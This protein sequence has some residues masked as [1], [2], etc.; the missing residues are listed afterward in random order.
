MSPTLSFGALQSVELRTC[1]ADEAR[2]LTP[3]VA[4]EDGLKLLGAALDIELACESCEVPVGPFSADILA[5]DLTTNSLVVIENQ[6]ERTNHDHFGKTLTYA[7]VLG[8]TTVV[9]IAR[10]FT[11]E[12]RK[13]LEWLNELARGDLQ[14]YGV[15]LQVWKIGDSAPAPRFEV[16]CSPNELVQAAT[17]ARDSESSPT[18]QL[19]LEFWTAVKEALQRTGEFSSLHTPRGQYWFDIAIGRSSMNL[20]L[21]ANTDDKRV[22]IRLY[23]SWRVADAVLRQLE[24]QRPEIDAAIGESLEWNPHPEKSDKTIRLV[25]AADIGDRSAWPEIISWLTKRAI[26]FKQVF[27]PRLLA[28]DLSSP[29][30]GESA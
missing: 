13:A 21:T 8:A 14:L 22:G 28:I 9:W 6:L 4:S 29:S 17:R 18:R 5:R 27:G 10:T 15:E 19:Q 12:H 25:R 3:W 1:W 26:V 16:V 2:N 24:P 20:S 30:A 11:D 7:A 23:L